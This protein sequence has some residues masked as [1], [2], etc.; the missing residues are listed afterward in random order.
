MISVLNRDSN[1]FMS[2]EWACTTGGVKYILR[3]NFN[4]DVEI[5][6]GQ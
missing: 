1:I 5:Q 2:Q 6:R 4:V 3:R